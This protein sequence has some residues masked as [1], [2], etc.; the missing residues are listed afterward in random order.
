MAKS[1]SVESRPPSATGVVATSSS[2]VSRRGGGAGSEGDDVVHLVFTQ[3]GSCD[4]IDVVA[5]HEHV[6]SAPGLLQGRGQAAVPAT[7]VVDCRQGGLGF[8][9]F[10]DSFLR[11]FRAVFTNGFPRR[12]QPRG[13]WRAGPARKPISRSSWQRKALSPHDNA[14]CCGAHAKGAPDQEGGCL[15]R[16]RDCQCQRSGHVLPHPTSETRV[17]MRLPRLRACCRACTMLSVFFTVRIIGRVVSR[18]RSVMVCTICAS[19]AS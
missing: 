7:H 12:G 13:S 3:E 8:K 14:H 2:A 17:T 5:N 15:P 9:K 19:L 1:T 16:R 10:Q 11:Q 6:I 18:A 4:E